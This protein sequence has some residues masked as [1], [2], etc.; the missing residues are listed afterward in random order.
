MK[1]STYALED[2]VRMTESCRMT[3]NWEIRAKGWYT[4]IK[5][6]KQIIDKIKEGMEK[7]DNVT[8]NG[9]QVRII[10]RDGKDAWEYIPGL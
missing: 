5:D 1:I 10:Q 8:V 7:G 6:P 4:V 9:H 2:I 3:E